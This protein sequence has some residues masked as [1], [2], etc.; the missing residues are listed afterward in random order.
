MIRRT[1]DGLD[2]VQ[3]RW[4][5]RNAVGVAVLSTVLIGAGTAHGHASTASPDITGYRYAFQG[6]GNLRPRRCRLLVHHSRHR[7]RRDDHHHVRRPTAVRRQ[8]IPIP[9]GS[10]A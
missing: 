6:R 4:A 2:P 5:S 8:D 3:H 9:E 1:P 7:R 10:P